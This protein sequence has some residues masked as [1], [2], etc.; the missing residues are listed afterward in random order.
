MVTEPATHSSRMVCP[1]CQ[2]KL[3][4]DYDEPA[5]LRCGYVDYSYVPTKQVDE[6]SVLSS[7]TKMRVRYG[8][9]ERHLRKT[10]CLV[11]KRKRSP[12]STIGS[13]AD[14]A[15]CPF[16]GLVMRQIQEAAKRNRGY[17]RHQCDNN[18]V[19]ALVPIGD[20]NLVW[21]I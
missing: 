5:C 7:A 10:L 17:S 8:G 9:D 20:G 3:R 16:D 21:T 18:H 14:E 1:R 4:I 19:I 15:V 11:N 2:G 13:L 12:G 6:Q